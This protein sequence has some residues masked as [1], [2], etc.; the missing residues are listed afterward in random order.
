M[1]EK[2]AKPVKKLKKLRSK[3]LLRPK[4]IKKVIA[5]KNIIKNA[6]LI[7]LS[8]FLFLYAVTI[9]FTGKIAVNSFDGEEFSKKAQEAC[10][11]IIQTGDFKYK[12][13]PNLHAVM[14][15]YNFSADWV[16]NQKLFSAKKIVIETKNPF[17]VFTKNFDIDSMYLSD[18][19]Y[20]D[21]ILP[22]G[23]NKLSSFP[24]GFNSKPFGKNKIT[25]K[26]GNVKVKNFKITYTTP[27]TYDEKIMKDRE[28][29]KQEV[30][31]FLYEHPFVS[32][33]IK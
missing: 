12:V 3:K 13:K 20:A 14:T 23:V 7:I 4:K 11:L 32:V 6:G 10:G 8:F 21:Q 15:V 24:A 28:Y 33:V 16:G 1:E 19:L 18:V 26:P 31:A 30:K 5:D 22:N 29:S 25:L 9:S 17:A 2:K 27:N